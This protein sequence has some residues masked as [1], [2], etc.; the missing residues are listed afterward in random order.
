M[1]LDLEKKLN[2]INRSHKNPEELFAFL[3]AKTKKK[4]IDRGD[5]E[6]VS[7]SRQLALLEEL[8]SFPLGRHIFYT[9]G[10]NGYWTDY[11]VYAPLFEKALKKE[12]NS[13]ETFLK[14]RS[15]HVCAQRELFQTFVK[16]T[17]K[18]LKDDMV[19]ASVP[20]GMM[21]DLFSL[22]LSMVEDVH[23]VGIDIDAEVLQNVQEKA[24]QKNINAVSLYQKDAWNLDMPEAFDL[25]NSI[26]LN[27]YEQDHVQVINLYKQLHK[28][29]KS[30]GVLFTGVLTYPPT[31]TKKGDWI[32]SGMSQED[33][34]LEKILHKDI[35]DINWQNFRHL[36]E[37]INDFKEAGF[38]EVTVV[39]DKHRVFPGVIAKK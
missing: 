9:K 13:I 26:G 39:L 37:I 5:L 2:K 32:L 3:L 21:R 6:Y 1:Y 19:I 10:A 14:Y 25:I 22:D 20:C 11:L 8:C 7:V 35:L 18:L 28:S 16:T 30:G 34:L 17:N 23:L 4:L 15:P 31:H 36:D 29:L 27:V 38:S 24:T 33:I 12:A